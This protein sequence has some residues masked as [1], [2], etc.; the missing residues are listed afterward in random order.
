MY[1]LERKTKDI[2]P[3][4]HS[5]LNLKGAYHANFHVKFYIYI[6]YNILLLLYYNI[7]DLI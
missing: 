4:C 3:K 6:Y 2:R 7:I 1:I 5:S